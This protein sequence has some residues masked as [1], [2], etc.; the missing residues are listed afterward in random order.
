[1]AIIDLDDLCYAWELPPILSTWKPETGLIHQTCLLKTSTE[2]YA[3]R[4]YRYQTKDRWY[5]ECEHAL[6]AYVRVHGLPSLAP[7][8]LPDGGTILEHKEHFYALFPFA[9]GHQV[10]RAQLTTYEAAIMGSF[11]GKL[12]HV[13]QK[14]PQK[15]VP[16][17][18][19]E[20]DRTATFAKLDEIEQV[21]RVQPQRNEIDNQALTRLTQQRRWLESA[22]PVDSGNLS[23]LEHQVIHGDYQETN[24]FFEDNYVSAIIDWDQAY[25][26]PRSW[27][28]IRTLHYAFKLE[29]SLCSTFLRAYRQVFPLQQQD[30][31]MAAAAYGWKRA[32][33]TW[34]HEAFYLEGNQRIHPLT[35]TFIPF[36]E[37]W[38]L[39]RRF[40][41]N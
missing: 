22:H 3:L 10:P 23:L 15:D 7:V 36:V 27:E 4:A 5:I 29:V 34:G 39:L 2:S 20:V 30:L 1:M 37:Q 19:F 32:H 41:I 28:I 8:P 21:I 17:R 12:H 24:L 31:D 18:S 13:L 38:A 16:H 11:L 40:L 9:R 6:I 25:V 14:Y 26:A 35:E 33:D